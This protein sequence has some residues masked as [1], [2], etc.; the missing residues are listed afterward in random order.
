MANLGAYSDK[1]LDKLISGFQEQIIR[2]RN[3][4]KHSKIAVFDMDGTLLDGDLEEAV[5]CFLI[6]N[7]YPVKLK[8]SNYLEMLDREDY[9]NAYIALKK[10]LDG[11]K[12]DAIM[13]FAEKLLSSKHSTIFFRE[14]NIEYQYPIPKINHELYKLL[15]YLKINEWKIAVISASTQ[16]LVRT[17]AENFLNL[18]TNYIRGTRSEFFVT[19]DCEDIFTDRITG[20]ITYGQGK[21]DSFKEMFFDEK[22][23]ISAGDSEGDIEL[24]NYTHKDGFVITCGK[25]QGNIQKLRNQLDADLH[26]VDFMY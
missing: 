22:P 12:A 5:Y 16:V 24:L 8:W 10:G 18:S 3:I 9:Q 13:N 26:K 2:I 17:L 23:M 1:I 11:I 7:N 14:G 4:E 25:S 6:A 15:I 19:E 21:I 20:I